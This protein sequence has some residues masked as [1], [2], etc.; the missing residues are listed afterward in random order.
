[1]PG[2]RVVP[3]SFARDQEGSLF[4][5]ATELK[6]WDTPKSNP[7]V[8]M[9]ASHY[10]DFSTQG[11]FTSLANRSFFSTCTYLLCSSKQQNGSTHTSNKFRLE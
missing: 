10:L 9:A 4:V 8:S 2:P 11:E 5:K 6:L 1:M 7:M 3:P